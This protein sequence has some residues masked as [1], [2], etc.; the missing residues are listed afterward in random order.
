MA[1]PAG[2]GKCV[3]KAIAKPDGAGQAGT[4]GCRRWVVLDGEVPAPAKGARMKAQ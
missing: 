3:L 1:V 4:T 2:S